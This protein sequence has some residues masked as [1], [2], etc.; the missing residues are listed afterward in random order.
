MGLTRVV[1]NRRAGV[2]LVSI[3]GAVANVIWAGLVAMAEHWP[4]VSVVAAF[5]QQGVGTLW[6]DL[7]ADVNTQLAIMAWGQRSQ[8]RW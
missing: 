7:S 5:T 2:F 6:G 4:M 8:S 1:S 3:A